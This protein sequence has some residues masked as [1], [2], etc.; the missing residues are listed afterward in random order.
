MNSTTF[1]VGIVCLLLLFLLLCIIDRREHNQKVNNVK[2]IPKYRYNENGEDEDEDEEEDE[3][4]VERFY[5]IDCE[6]VP[7]NWDDTF[8]I[9]VDKETRVQYIEINGDD[10]LTVLIDGDGKPIL[11]TGNFDEE[12]REDEEDENEEG[13]RF[14]YIDSEDVPGNWDDTFNIIVDKKTRVQYLDFDTCG[15][16]ALIGPDGKPILY[17]GNFDE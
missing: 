8:N 14:Y 1:V 6:D 2:Y 13:E 10:G 7:G 17:T 3:E 11:Y 16:T 4:E 9:I 15:L 5:Y 12:C